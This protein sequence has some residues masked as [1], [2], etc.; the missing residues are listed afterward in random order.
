MIDL[1]D[2]SKLLLLRKFVI[3]DLQSLIVDHT[4]VTMILLKQATPKAETVVAWDHT[5]TSP[6][7]VSISLS[8]FLTILS[9][10]WLSA[11]TQPL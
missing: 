10:L 5:M 1:N 4:S 7:H 9:T 3:A 2:V 8:S 6:V 11:A